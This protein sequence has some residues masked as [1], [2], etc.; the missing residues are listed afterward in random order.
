MTN[1]TFYGT[2]RPLPR[3]MLCAATE[4]FCGRRWFVKTE[5]EYE[6]A[7]KERQTHEVLCES[8]TANADKIKHAFDRRHAGN[9]PRVSLS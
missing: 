9:F 8:M 6:N 3:L 1:D 2:P 7:V 5:A 4:K